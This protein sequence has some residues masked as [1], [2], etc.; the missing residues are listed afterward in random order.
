MKKAQERMNKITWYMEFK[1]G[2]KVWL[3]GTHLK[4]PYSTMK[5]MPRQY[6]PFKVVARISSVAFKLELLTNWKIHPIFHASLLTPY[7]ET[8]AHGQNVLEPPL[9]LING[10]QEWEIEEILDE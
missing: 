9:E 7:K 1:E 8:E 5:L 10:E 6:G 2:E 3:E 4:L